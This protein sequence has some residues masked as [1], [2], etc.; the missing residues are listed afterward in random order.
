MGKQGHP[1]HAQT[2]GAHHATL[3]TAQGAQ[4]SPSGAER[5]GRKAA[6]GA[7]RAGAHPAL[8]QPGGLD[9]VAI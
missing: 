6:A 3:V 7:V 4:A 2:P 9:G 8:G 1:V 5:L